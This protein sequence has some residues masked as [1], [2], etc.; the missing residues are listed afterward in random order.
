M[1][2]LRN[3]QVTLL[4]LFKPAFDPRFRYVSAFCLPPS[5][6]IGITIPTDIVSSQQPMATITIDVPDERSEQLQQLGGRLPQLLQQCLQQPPLPARS[7]SL[8]AELFS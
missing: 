1:V 7:L 8:C 3:A 2:G 5:A 4:S 6:F